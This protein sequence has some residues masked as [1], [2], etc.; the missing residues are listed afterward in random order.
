MARTPPTSQATRIAVN[1]MLLAAMNPALTKTPVPIMVPTLTPMPV[2]SPRRGTGA[3]ADADAETEVAGVLTW[4]L[5]QGRAC[6]DVTAHAL[7]RSDAKM[8]GHRD[9]LCAPSARSPGADR[10]CATGTRRAGCRQGQAH[11]RRPLEDQ[12]G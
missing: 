7:N 10:R 5:Y 9:R 11:R 3:D 4:P 2:Q 1:V 12:V 6:P 8:D